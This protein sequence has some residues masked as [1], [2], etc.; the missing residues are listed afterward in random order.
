MVVELPIGKQLEY[1]IEHH[2]LDHTTAEMDPD[3][4]SDVNSGGCYRKLREEGKIDD[5]TLTLQ[6]NA[7]GARFFNVSKFGFWPF[8]ALVNEAKY[9]RRRS[10]VIL[11][12][13]WFGNK[14]TP[15]S[16]FMDGFLERLKSLEKDGFVYNGILFKVRVLV[17]TVDT[18]ARSELNST[19]RCNGEDG[20]DFCLHPGEQI[21]R[22]VRVYPQPDAEAEKDTGREPIVYPLRTLEQHRRDVKIAEASGKRVN[23]II[24]P[25]PFMNIPKFDFVKALVPDYFIHCCCQGVY[26][27]FINIFTS[28]KRPNGQQSWFLGKNKMKIINARLKQTRPPYRITRKIERMDDT[29]DWKAS[30]YRTFTLYFF[31][32]LED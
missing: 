26:K 12:A 8:M 1:F 24:G 15:R 5:R 19:T 13:I 22:G 2:G 3:C 10:F 6:L 11:L 25:N 30:T 9:G 28:T 20:C 4:R 21:K 31:P 29:S 23:G 27:L 17:I 16:V 18:I 14:K 32:L 7:D